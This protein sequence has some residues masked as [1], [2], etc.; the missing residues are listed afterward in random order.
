MNVAFLIAVDDLGE[1]HPARKE[2]RRLFLLVQRSAGDAG[3]HCLFGEDVSLN[4]RHKLGKRQRS[5]Q[6]LVAVG[7]TGRVPVPAASV[8]H[9]KRTPV[10]ANQGIR[11][12]T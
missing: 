12:R 1:P 4:L 9:T 11:S 8:I 7:I 10:R 3:L 6:G 2:N 5:R